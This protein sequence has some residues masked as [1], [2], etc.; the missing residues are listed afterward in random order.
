MGVD[1]GLVA[2]G[3]GVLEAEPG[4]VT[5]VDAGVISTTTGQPLEAR[6]NAL[7]RAVH[8]IIELQAPGLLVVEDLYT[9]YRFPR[10]AILMG[11]ARGVIYLA[12]RQLGVTVVA[13]A[14]SEVKRAMTGNGAAG[15]AQVQRAVQTVLGLREAPRPSHVADALGLAVT[16][17][18]RITGR[19]PGRSAVVPVGAT[20]GARSAGSFSSSAAP[21]LPHR[22]TTGGESPI[23][24]AG[25]IASLRGRLRRKLEDRIVVE[26]AGVGYEIFVP[27]VTQQE[28][29]NAKA[30]EGD[31]AD[32]V[33]LAI[34]YH[35]TQNQ[36]RPVLIGFTSELDRE[37]FEKL[38]TVKDV[39]PLVAARSLAAPVGEIAAAIARQ[40]EG[41]LRRLPGIGPQKAKNIVAQLQAKVAKFALARPEAAVPEPAGAPAAPDEE[42]LRG[43]VFEILVK[44]LG[45][46]PSE[47][48][49][50]ISAA[51]QRRPGVTTPEE[52][53]DEI[54]RGGVRP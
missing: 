39:G 34:H 33:A 7:H 54:Y 45:H 35:A 14:P 1:P 27:P 47:A 13:L 50:L 9:E 10:T 23:W 46:R 8:R 51:L 29:V 52:L 30:A 26:A 28:L 2:T 41:Y 24:G 42:G 31:A 19:L 3:F 5:V 11:H 38:I 17:M 18:S 4:G 44:Q 48:A 15:K 40:D 53:F 20:G 25:V 6:L 21:A 37:F 36:P 12:A 49:Q 43:M 16:G 32:E 22:G